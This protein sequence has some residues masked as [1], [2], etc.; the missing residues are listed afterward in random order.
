V[1]K[2][3][4][5]RTLVRGA[6]IGA[7]V[8]IAGP[9][10]SLLPRAARA[11]TPDGAFRQGVAS[12]EPGQRA[13]TVWTRLD[14][15]DRPAVVDL[16][17]AAGRAL[18]ADALQATVDLRAD[19]LGGVLYGVLGRHEAPVTERG[20]ANAVEAMR[21]LCDAAAREGVTI[22]LEVVNRYESNVLTRPNRR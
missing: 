2:R 6:A 19:Y 17:V 9:A 10:Y 20:Y 14:E 7:G 1:T 12:G 16:E 11:A 5:R 4:D 18:L 22:G 15:L 21:E 3:I 8:L 13:I